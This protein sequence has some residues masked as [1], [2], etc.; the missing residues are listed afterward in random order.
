MVL[1]WKFYELL[2]LVEDLWSIRYTIIFHLQEKKTLVSFFPI[3]S[4]L[5]SFI[6]LF[7]PYK[8]SNISLNKYWEMEKKSCLYLILLE[9]FWVSLH[10]GWF[11]AVVLVQTAFNMLRNISCK[12]LCWGHLSERGFWFC[13]RHFYVLW[14]DCVVF[15]IQSISQWTTLINLYIL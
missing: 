12:H 9:M 15:V 6:F 7:V 11:L 3:W 8:F 5:V 2:E 10:L 13:Q 1:W 14:N 4:P